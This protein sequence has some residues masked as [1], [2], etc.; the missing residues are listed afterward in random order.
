MSL[1]ACLLLAGCA[2][3]R[4]L[5]D[6]PYAHAQSVPPLKPVEGIKLPESTAALKI[7]PPPA[8][9]VPFGQKVKDEKGEEVVQC[10]DRPPPMPKPVEEKPA[11]EKPATESKP[12]EKSP[13]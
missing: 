7:P 10:L 1:F 5:G 12:V 11:E 2:G 13:G 6:P 8:N 3:N 4:C 9:A